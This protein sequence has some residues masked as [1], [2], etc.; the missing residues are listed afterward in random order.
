MINGVSSNYNLTNYNDYNLKNDKNLNQLNNEI[1]KNG[2]VAKT[3]CQTCKSRKYVD[4]SNESNV[5]FKTPSHIS[6]QSSMSMVASHERE[7]VSNAIKEG[8]KE[9][10]KLLSVSVSLETSICPE[11]GRSYVSGG[12]TE[13]TMQKTIEETKINPYNRGEELVKRHF[14]QGINVDIAV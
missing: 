3:E 5:S 4:G 9:G 13:T 8:N 6:P 2:K 12:I 7:H 1:Q 10:N 14:I 11:C